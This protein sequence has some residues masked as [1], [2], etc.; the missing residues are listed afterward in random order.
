M[1]GWG[2]RILPPGMPLRA[3]WQSLHCYGR[4]AVAPYDLPDEGLPIWARDSLSTQDPME[5][6][7]LSCD[8]KQLAE[9]PRGDS[10]HAHIPPSISSLYSPASLWHLFPPWWQ[11]VGALESQATVTGSASSTFQAT[12]LKS[13]GESGE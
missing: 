1:I 5:L 13:C 9:G 8:G 12:D 4:G 11:W 10:A 7:R 2:V 3:L 6:P